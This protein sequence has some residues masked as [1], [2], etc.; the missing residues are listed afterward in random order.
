M[1]LFVTLICS[2]VLL[3]ACKNDI[4][5]D[6]HFTDLLAVAGKREPGSMAP[7]QLSVELVDPAYCERSGD[8]L[9]ALLDDYFEAPEIYACEPDGDRATLTLQIFLPI[10]PGAA[11][12]LKANNRVLGLYPQDA[13]GRIQ[14]DVLYSEDVMRRLM[15]ALSEQIRHT[16]C[17]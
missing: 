6:L 15:Q 8:D 13:E 2:G 14:I 10:Y 12:W 16:D 3:T 9:I 7:A 5:T 1:R 11:D 17:F 4:V